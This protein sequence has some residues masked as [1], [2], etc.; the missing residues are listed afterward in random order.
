MKMTFK[1]KINAYLGMSKRNILLFF[2]DKTT[3]FF[4]LLAPL[5]VFA[6]Y[7]VFLKDTYLSGIYN[8][9]KGLESFFDIKEI[10]NIANGWL[11]AGILGTSTITVSLNSLQIMV[12]DKERKV[13]FDYNSSPISGPCVV[14]SYFTGAFIN[15]FLVSGSILTLGLIVLS[16]MGNLHLTVVSI[17]LLYL[18]T[19]VGSASSTI[20][21]MVVTS[22]FKTSSSLG[23]FSGIISAAIGFVIGAYIPLGNFSKT[24]QGVLTIVP[25]SHIACI[26]RNLLMSGTLNS[27][28][29]S[30][31]GIDGGAFN[32]MIHELFAFKLNLFSYQTSML[33]MCLYSVG[34]I[35][36]GLILNVLLYR[37]AQKRV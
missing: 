1:Q 8:E 9:V 35:V 4:S 37:R 14:F 24:I 36:I 33:F 25:G 26:Y 13:D 34:S 19:I 2:K 27:I 18:V 28:N 21:M 6:L 10:D 20:L 30:L 11:L 7:I 31:N 16:I 12:I 23:A 22:F 3:L 29:S 32:D 5:I 17:L 15:T